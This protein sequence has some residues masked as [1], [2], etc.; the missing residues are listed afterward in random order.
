[1][2]GSRGNHDDDATFSVCQDCTSGDGDKASRR[3][4]SKQAR[5]QASKLAGNSGRPAELGGN[6]GKRWGIWGT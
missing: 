3:K 5:K 6:L 4:P 2:S 1:M